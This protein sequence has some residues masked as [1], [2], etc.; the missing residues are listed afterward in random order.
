VP[1][2]CR[3]YGIIIRMYY[4]DHGRPHFQAK[5]GGEEISVDIE[6]M[7]IFEGSLPPRAT[8]MVREWADL[9]QSELMEK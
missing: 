8:K 7:T 4:R 6:H 9:H 2:I 3:F 1:E 5:Y